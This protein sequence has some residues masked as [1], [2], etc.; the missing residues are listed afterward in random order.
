[1]GPSIILMESIVIVFREIKYFINQFVNF[2][3]IRK[4]T[5]LQ[6]SLEIKIQNDMQY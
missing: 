2:I 3:R 5:D 4:Y 1:M 6:I